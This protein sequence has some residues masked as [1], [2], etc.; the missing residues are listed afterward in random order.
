MVT[1][2]SLSEIG[3][4]SM[5]KNINPDWNWI[6]LTYFTILL[7]IFGALGIIILGYNLHSNNFS[8][9]GDGKKKVNTIYYDRLNEVN[10]EERI[11]WFC[12]C[13][14]RNNAKVAQEENA[15][16]TEFEEPSRKHDLDFGYNQMNKL[17]DDLDEAHKKLRRVMKDLD[18]KRAEARMD[19]DG[20]PGEF[21]EPED[22]LIEE[23]V[24]FSAFIKANRECI[25]EINLNAPIE[26]DWFMADEDKDH[27][28]AEHIEVTEHT[29]K[30]HIDKPNNDKTGWF[31]AKHLESE[32]QF[33]AGQRDAINKEQRALFEKE[34]E[35]SAKVKQDL[36]DRFKESMRDSNLTPAE[37]AAMLAEMNAKI[38]HINDMIAGEEKAQHDVLDEAL[39]KRRAKKMQLRDL[40]ETLSEKKGQV[41]EYFT[42]KMDEIS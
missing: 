29:V 34:L 21:K 23:L 33:E 24:A 13:F 19:E 20:N 16:P 25:M 12:K 35:R 38:S 42:K 10:D 31:M 5:L 28:Q 2:Q 39:A 3:I 14:K 17:K 30:T 8:L 18:R 26:G 7:F 27:L 36:V 11:K 22:E 15:E 32:Q 41:D 40:V 6:G 37:Q 4:K 9:F 1:E